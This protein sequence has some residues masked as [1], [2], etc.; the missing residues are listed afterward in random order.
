MIHKIKNLSRLKGKWLS[1]VLSFYLKKIIKLKPNQNEIKTFNF[2]SA[3]VKNNYRIISYNKNYFTIKNE[4]NNMKLSL[5]NLPSSDI[6]VF[7]Q[8]FLNKEYKE[9]FSIADKYFG[10]QKMETILDLGGN[11]GLTSLFLLFQYPDSRVIIL[12]PDS[13]NFKTLQ[14][15]LLVNNNFKDNTFAC[16]SGIWSNDAK[17]KISNK[18]RDGLDWSYRVEE[19]KKDDGIHAYSICSL[20]EKYNIKNIDILKIDVEGTEKILFDCNKTN[21]DFLKFTKIIAIEIH[22]EICKKSDIYQVFEKYGFVFYED[23]ELSFAY[24]SNLTD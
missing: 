12:E 17:L 22:E 23:G 2:Y 21:L 15:N 18:F 8:I 3:L 11:I 10:K 4:Y 14:L 20:C 7:Y 24:N 1:T 13:N 5:R 16:N 19:S 9:V 6:D